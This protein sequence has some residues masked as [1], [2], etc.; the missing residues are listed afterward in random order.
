MLSYYWSRCFVHVVESRLI[1]FISCPAYLGRKKEVCQM[2][3]LS[4]GYELVEPRLSSGYEL[5]KPR[6]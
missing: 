5:V 2:Y 4:S 6:M 1:Y 3:C